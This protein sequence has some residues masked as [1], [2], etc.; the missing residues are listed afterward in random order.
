MEVR[1]KPANVRSV[2]DWTAFTDV[3]FMTFVMGVL[4]GFASCYVPVFYLSY[5]GTASSITGT[6][7]AFY[8]IPILN[9]G[10]ISGRIVPNWLSDK[11]GP[12]NVIVPSKSANTVQAP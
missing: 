4:T 8:I 10:S 2:I 11:I 6:S 3:P 7:L 9:F 12:L 1:V 5:F